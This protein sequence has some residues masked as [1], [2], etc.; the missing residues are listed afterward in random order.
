[1]SGSRR[2]KSATESLLQIAVGL[3]IALVFFGALALN[4]LRLY[5]GVVV[6]VGSLVATA[7]LLVL[8]RVV[9]YPAGRVFGHVVQL[10][11]L[12]T[13]FWDVV[14]GISAVVMVG[15]WIFG[16]IRGPQLDRLASD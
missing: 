7:V 10:A 2:D 1:V 11:L 4:G 8:Y 14:M 6:V 15:F 3:E 5:P 9:A 12:G 13:F 16:A